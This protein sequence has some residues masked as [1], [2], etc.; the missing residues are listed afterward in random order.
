M[1]NACLYMG[2]D[3]F[4]SENHYINKLIYF[5]TIFNQCLTKKYFSFMRTQQKI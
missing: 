4:L 1:E 3:N 2:F 5:N